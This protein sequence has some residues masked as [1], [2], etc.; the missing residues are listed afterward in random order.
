MR[1]ALTG[2]ASGIGAATAAL[3]RG[4]GDEVV[5]FDVNAPAPKGSDA[6]GNGASDDDRSFVRLDLMDESSVDDAIEKAGGGFDG[7]CSIAG[8]PP[9]E[10]NAVAC[11]VVNAIMTM[12]FIEGFLPRLNKGAAVV[13]VASRAGL[14]WQENTRQLD[15][16]LGCAPGEV[17]GWCKRHE[18]DPVAAYR[19]SKQAVIHR[20]QCLVGENVGRHRFVTVSPAAVSTGILDDF[21]KAFGPKVAANLERVGRAGTPMEVASLIAYLVSRE[22]SWINGVDIAVDGGMGALNAARV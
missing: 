12:R 9:R 7:L 10:D 17:A 19:I 13:S 20:H 8:I 15:D 6:R 1:I 18:I 11:L 22:A 5:V 16:L 14:G 4:R 21:I 2:G 3:L